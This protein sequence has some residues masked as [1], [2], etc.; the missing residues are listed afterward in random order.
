[1]RVMCDYDG[2]YDQAPEVF[3]AFLAS[4]EALGH[5]V[6]IVTGRSMENP[7]DLSDDFKIIYTDGAAKIPFCREFWGITFDIF[8]ED[9]PERLLMDSETCHLIGQPDSPKYEEPTTH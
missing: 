9:R 5:E 3:S 8:I 6:Y 1:M 7:I 2:T 4:L